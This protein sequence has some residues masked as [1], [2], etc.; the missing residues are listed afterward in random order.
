M[1]KASWPRRTRHFKEADC[2]DVQHV[3]NR[4][5]SNLFEVD[6]CASAI[7][8]ALDESIAAGVTDIEYE[9]LVGNL[10]QVSGEVR[11]MISDQPADIVARR[12]A[13]H[14]CPL[15]AVAGQALLREVS[16][17]AM[18]ALRELRPYG[19]DTIDGFFGVFEDVLMS[20]R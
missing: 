1:K 7:C 3:N 18:Q 6:F 12:R 9:S 10:R 19:D 5:I 13:S 11:D 4:I 16:L 20:L 8:R 14:P 17:R 15:Q 2:S